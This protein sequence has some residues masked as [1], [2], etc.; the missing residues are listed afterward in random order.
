MLMVLQ[1]HAYLVTMLN[2]HNAFCLLSDLDSA[3]KLVERKNICSRI[4][5]QPDG[6][7][8]KLPQNILVRTRSD[9]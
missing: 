3:D 5:D 7:K 8:F 4:K 2:V 1:F 9:N 6:V